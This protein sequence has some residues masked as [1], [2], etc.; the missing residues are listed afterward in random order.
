MS[1]VEMETDE[2]DFYGSDEE[3]EVMEESDEEESTAYETETDE[4]DPDDDDYEE[5]DVEELEVELENSKTENR[6]L[7][8]LVKEQF[9]L[10]ADLR[11]KAQK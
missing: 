4:D 8:K 11:K 10:I 3:T 2:G 1:D 5:V 7:R 9:R 6:E